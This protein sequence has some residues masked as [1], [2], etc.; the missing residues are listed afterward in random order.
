MKEIWSFSVE[1]GG[2]T[3]SPT[4]VNQKIVADKTGTSIYTRTACPTIKMPAIIFTDGPT[5]H[6]SVC[7]PWQLEDV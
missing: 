1:V 7:Q 2:K 4:A 6:G 5:V 3:I